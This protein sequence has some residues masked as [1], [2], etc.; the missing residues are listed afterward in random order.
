MLCLILITAGCVSGPLRYKTLGNHTYG[1]VE[2]T[3]RAT[4]IAKPIASIGGLVT[5]AGLIVTDTVVTPIIAIPYS[6]FGSA[7]FGSFGMGNNTGGERV[8]LSIILI[9]FAM[10]EFGYGHIDETMGF[11]RG[12]IWLKKETIRLQETGKGNTEQGP[13]PY[14][15]P[16]AAE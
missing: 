9:P 15:K 6:I 7:S 3:K 8:C 1:T 4:P 10:Y 14:A 16:E 2:F 12:G 11:G 5:D 13:S